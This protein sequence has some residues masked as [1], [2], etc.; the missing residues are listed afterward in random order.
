NKQ[1]DEKLMKTAVYGLLPR[2]LC[3]FN[4]PSS[5]LS[6]SD[7]GNYFAVEGGLTST[8]SAVEGGLTS[9]YSAGLQGSLKDISSSKRPKYKCLY[10][11]EDKL[12]EKKGLNLKMPRSAPVFQQSATLPIKFKRTK[13]N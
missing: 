1:K 6:Q 5:S 2:G 12:K 3:G 11:S 4:S 7:R 10:S 13:K 9:T 8:Y